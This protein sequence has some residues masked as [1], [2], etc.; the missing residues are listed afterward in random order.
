MFLTETTN[1]IT[2]ISSN[3]TQV[4]KNVFNLVSVTLATNLFISYTTS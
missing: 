2:H 4:N 1:K 3:E